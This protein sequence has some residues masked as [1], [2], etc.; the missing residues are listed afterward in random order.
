MNRQ[1]I[2]NKWNNESDKWN[3]WSCISGDEKFNLL[4]NAKDINIEKLKIEFDIES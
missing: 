2:I 3:K 1:E 4:K